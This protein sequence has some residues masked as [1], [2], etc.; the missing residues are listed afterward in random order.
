MSSKNMSFL[1]RSGGHGYSPTL[2]SIQDA[3]LINLENFNYVN[4]Q[5]KGTVV[6]GTGAYF[7]DLIDTVG[8]AGRELSTSLMSTSISYPF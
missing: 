4:V 5:D 6:V 3:V 8:G 1:A 7:G 2:Q